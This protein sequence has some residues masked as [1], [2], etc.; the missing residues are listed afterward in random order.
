MVPE[1]PAMSAASRE[2]NCSAGGN[3]QKDEITG[4]G[5][6]FDNFVSDA[7]EGPIDV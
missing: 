2:A 3:A 1:I 5:D 7:T 6:H 4:I